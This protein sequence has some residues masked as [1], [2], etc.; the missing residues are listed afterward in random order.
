MAIADQATLADVAK[1]YADAI[2]EEGSARQLWASSHSDYFELWLVTEPIDADVERQ[3]Y[4]AELILYERFP[5]ASLSVHVLNP[6]YFGD[7]DPAE[8]I[9]RDAEE[10][11]L[12]PA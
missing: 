8:M 7:S 10:V 1:T 12:R 5:E 2:R 3:L 11:Q 4:T 9:P 6:R